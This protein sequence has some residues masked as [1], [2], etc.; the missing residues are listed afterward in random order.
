MFAVSVAVPP[1]VPPAMTTP[2]VLV[3]EPFESV[4]APSVTRPEVVCELPPRLSVAPLPSVI[5]PVVASRSFPPER[6]TVPPLTARP[7]VNVLVPSSVSVPAPSFVRPPAPE[8]VP[9][10]E[11]FVA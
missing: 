7:P 6:M 3:S 2:P 8:I 5:R 9:D 1:S 11:V 4:P 10:A